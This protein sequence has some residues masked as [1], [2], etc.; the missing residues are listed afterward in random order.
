MSDP[1]STLAPHFFQV[2]YVVSDLAKAEE[3]FKSVMGVPFFMRS[4]GV[5]LKEDC[6]YRGSPADSEM[7]LSLGFVRGTQV[8]LIEHVR[9][10]SIYAEFL[11]AKGPGLHHLGF[12]VPDFG[13][14]YEMMRKNGLEPLSEGHLGT[15]TDFAYFDCEAAG[16]S[17][18][19]LLGFD[20]ATTAMMQQLRESSESAD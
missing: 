1:L 15:G 13:A 6:L 5:V 18:I 8:E 17:I 16:A 19:E 14:A 20:E 11:E 2:G 4:D 10:P 3:W 12:T 9:G 7:N